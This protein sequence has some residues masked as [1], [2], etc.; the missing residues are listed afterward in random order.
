MWLKEVFKTNKPV[1]GMVH[2]HA[3]PTDPKYDETKGI[4]EIVEAARFDLNALQEG[5]ID[6][7]LFCNEFSIPYTKNVRGIT[8]ATF[9]RVVGELKKDIKV[10]FGITCSSS[11]EYT[12]DIAV[13]T[14]ADFART[15]IQGASQGVY[16]INDCD[17]GEIA[18]HKV[19]IGGKNLKVLTA[20]VPEGTRQIAPRPLEEV[21]KTLAFNV[22]PDG[23][24][25]YSTNPGA[26]IDI[27]QVKTIKKVTDIPVLASNGVKPNTIEEIL[28]YADGCIVG[29]GIKFD[30][31]FY[32]Q[33]DVNRVKELMENARK[34]QA[35]YDN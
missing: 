24:L 7:V 27:E 18:R 16:G 35:Q 11:P 5:G 8:V 3:M 14:G 15:H 2:L 34:V 13:A 21:A 1:I 17:P 9:A 6:A 30:G 4:E 22:A 10:P 29:T 26:S 25:V 19:V 23:I 32:N 12:Y 31:S 33:I 28:T 20:I